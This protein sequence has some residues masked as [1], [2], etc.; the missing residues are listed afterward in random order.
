MSC[1]NVPFAALHDEEHDR[2]LIEDY[3][4]FY[5]PSAT[6]W[7]RIQRDRPPISSHALV[8]G[9]PAGSLGSLRYA[10]PEATMVAGRLD[11]TALLGADA[12]ERLIHDLDP[13]V[14]LLHVAAHALYD[15]ANPLFSFIALAPEG[16]KYDGNLEA[17]EVLADVD[18]KGVNLVVVSACSTADGKPSAGD[19]IVGLT[20][21]LLYAGTPAVLSTLWE[22]NDL[23][24]T[25]LMDA[26]YE[27]LASGVPAADA[28]REAQLSMLHSEIFESPRLWAAFLLHGDPRVTWQRRGEASPH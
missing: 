1:T 9:D 14:D 15:G 12:C 20:R 7:T 6:A 25:A 5:A 21:A 26:F 8:L 24:A 16:E 11:T 19:E 18:L 10:G 28:L 2:Y 13:K 23:A 22:I 17:Q 4:I 27:R 3:T